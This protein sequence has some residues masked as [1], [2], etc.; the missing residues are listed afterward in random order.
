M[1][2]THIGYSI[3]FVS[4]IVFFFSIGQK[5]IDINGHGTSYIILDSNISGKKLAP[6]FHYV[7]VKGDTVSLS[8]FRGKYIYFEIWG[9]W[10]APCI[11][12][13]P[14]FEKLK[15]KFKDEDIVF[16]SIAIDSDYEKWKQFVKK[17]NM[18]GIQ[19]QAGGDSNL[20]CYFE[21]NN[22]IL[23]RR[24][25]KFVIIDKKGFIENKKAPRPSSKEIEIV[26][27]DLMQKD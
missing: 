11:K 22:G 25:P 23:I 1:K 18:T 8:D 6:N 4:V 14:Y 19:L 10:C 21:R 16:L 26:L 2:N 3:L 9:T 20:E 12:Q 27:N 17:N 5:N 24:I 15:T 7:D 13:I